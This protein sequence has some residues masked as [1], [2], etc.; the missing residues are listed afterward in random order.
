MQTSRRGGKRKYKLIEL[1]EASQDLED[2]LE[3][4]VG[5]KED[6]GLCN[7]PGGPNP[8]DGSSHGYIDI[9]PAGLVVHKTEN[10][11]SIPYLFFDYMLIRGRGGRKEVQISTLLD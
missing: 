6:P 7:D 3:K 11:T 2:M 9:D 1:E 8:N 10:D 5:M 4:D